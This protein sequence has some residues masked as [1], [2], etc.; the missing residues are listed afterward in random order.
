MLLSWNPGSGC[1]RL[2]HVIEALGYHVACIQEA[3]RSQ[4]QD[5]NSLNRSW[6]L[7]CQQFVAARLPS[8]VQFHHGE[9]KPGKIRW[10]VFTV[11]F[12]PDRVGQKRLGVLSLHL[13]NVHAKKTCAGHEEVGRVL[14]AAMALCAVDVVCSDLNMAR[15]KGDAA[16][17]DGT[18]EEL[19]SRQYMPIA[20]YAQEC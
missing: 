5:I 10:A 6:M 1:K 9:D 16:W 15:W 18:L 14:D 7:E 17:H 4:L 13:N 2:V 19:E 8:Q 12:V 11:H 3:W 20:D